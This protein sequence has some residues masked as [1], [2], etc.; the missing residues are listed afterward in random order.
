MVYLIE[1]DGEFKN[2]YTKRDIREAILAFGREEPTEGKT[3]ENTCRPNYETTN[4]ELQKE[5]DYWK[6]EHQNLR[7]DNIRLEATLRTIE[8]WT[9]KNFM[10]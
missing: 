9:G 4:R 5:L 7:E 2:G 6:C 10:G 3:C 8:Q 1:L